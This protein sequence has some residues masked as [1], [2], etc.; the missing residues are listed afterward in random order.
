MAVTTATALAL[1]PL[2][3]PAGKLIAKIIQEAEKSSQN[4]EECGHLAGRLSSI[5]KL[6]P[7]LQQQEPWAAEELARLSG[8]LN[9]AHELVVAVQKWS[10]RRKFTRTGLAERFRLV[11]SRIDSHLIDIT[12]FCQVDKKGCPDSTGVPLP[13]PAT[14]SRSLTGLFG[15]V[16]LRT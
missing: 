4:K 9:D 13:L 14:A 7:R 2:A 10:G 16:K 8:T 15:V 5:H 6:L 1:A 3:F 12:A 11:N